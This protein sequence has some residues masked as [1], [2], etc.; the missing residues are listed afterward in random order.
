MPPSFKIFFDSLRRTPAVA[1]F[2]LMA[3]VFY[4]DK[5]LGPYG[6]IRLHD[7]FDVEFAR[8]KAAGELLFRH[9]FFAWYPVAAGGSPAY[10]HTS[11]PYHPLCLLSQFFPLW[12]LYGA[13][14]ITL[15]AVAG[16]GM[17]RFLNELL[18]LDRPLASI[19]G[20]VFAVGTQI[21]N[22]SIVH[23][24][25]NYAFPLFFV[26]TAGA[27]LKGRRI[28]WGVSLGVLATVFF[29]YAALTIPFFSLLH[30][31]LAWYV[32]GN[33]VYKRKGLLWQW[34]LLWGGYILVFAPQLYALYDYSLMTSRIY[35]PNVRGF[36]SYLAEFAVSLPVK[37]LV[38]LPLAVSLV[39]SRSAR[40]RHWLSLGAFFLAVSAFFYSSASNFLAG[41]FLPKMD[42]GHYFWTLGFIATVTTFVALAHSR[43]GLGGGRGI[44][45]VLVAVLGVSWFELSPDER[46]F[47]I[48]ANLLM[49]GGLFFFVRR[50][51]GEGTGLGRPLAIAL[52]VT[53]ALFARAYRVV[54][55]EHHSYERDFGNA[56]LLKSALARSA[57]GRIGSWQL[58]PAP[59]MSV[60]L[61][62][63]D[64]RGPFFYGPYKQ[65]IGKAIEGQFQTAEQA[66]EFYEYWYNLYLAN[67]DLRRG[68]TDGLLQK[69]NLPMLKAAHLTHLVSPG[70]LPE[71]E[72]VSKEVTVIKDE[73][74]WFRFLP[75]PLVELWRPVPLY[76][77][78][79]K[80]P[81]E[82]AYLAEAA[83]IL[84]TGKEVLSQM[85][86]SPEKLK[87]TVFFS[88]EDASAP[89]AAWAAGAFVGKKKL[90][91]ER[92]GPDELVFEAETEGPAVLV[93]S[94]NFHP[95]WT[96]SVEGEKTPVF[97]ANHTFQALYIGR[98]GKSRV[99][100]KYNDPWLWRLHLAIPLGILAILGGLWL[101]GRW[102][103]R[104]PA[105][106][107][108]ETNG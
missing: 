18:E 21:Q 35:S 33:D 97:R 63:L 98:A 34:A 12:F 91:L 82:R 89:S 100:L 30:L 38:V 58:P 29:S 24:V 93:V 71:M 10:A 88:Q 4:A 39:W 62:T 56:E 27:I 66:K 87:D 3:A 26:W 15:M 70:A 31:V 103:T 59:V 76:V 106:T 80:D 6:L 104:S 23:V 74:K 83:V 20:F 57:A 96:A 50:S 68:P 54:A 64:G 11:P 32:A 60:G 49:F 8:Y 75:G 47:L 107:L 105:T 43:G 65:F 72:T 22:E 69:I 90:K 36:F 9:G 41:T 52:F 42:L 44:L 37:G 67:G 17:Y 81:Q 46:L 84:P 51:A 55:Q 7:T 5:F 25:Y 77:Y 95:N 40:V 101:P 45:L 73:K 28:S 53:A 14:T 99:V 13:L 78:A 92:A 85:A 79:L 1:Y 19:G 108:L 61:E 16:Y 94:H 102:K 86:S 48:P 2:F